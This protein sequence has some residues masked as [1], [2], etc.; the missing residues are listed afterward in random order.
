MDRYIINY[1]LTTADVGVY[2][3]AV[4]CTLL[5]DF[6]LMGLTNS[7]I[8]KIFQIWSDGKINYSTM[9]VNRYYNAFTAITVLVIAFT[10]LAIPVLVPLIVYKKSYYAAF[11]FLPVLSLSFI[12]RGVYTMYLIPVLFFKKTKIL[13]KVFFFSAVIQIVVSVLMIKQWGL[14][15][16]VWSVL[17][18]KPIQ[19]LLLG[20]ESSKIF[21][22]TFNKIKL[23]VLP[24]VYL[25]IVICGDIFLSEKINSFL[26]HAF[27][28]VIA[29]G[30][31]FLIYRNEIKMLL[32][33]IFKFNLRS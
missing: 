25:L 17:I 6:I 7:I 13:P 2:D 5:I 27:E 9:E 20:Y 30:M 24:V 10:I 4:K 12:F 14:T 29:G 26:L 16:V 18:T 1:F 23:F 32:Q 33:S 15:G 22:F 11:V 28:F 8:P 19:V 31:I 21:S 3:F